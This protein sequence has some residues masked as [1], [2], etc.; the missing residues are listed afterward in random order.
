MKTDMSPKAVT[1]RLRLTSE[2]RDLC[3]A[4][5]G[6]RLRNK[7]REHL[8]ELERTAVRSNPKDKSGEFHD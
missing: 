3:I 1:E 6:E 7:M 5:G 8:R 2:L 4:L